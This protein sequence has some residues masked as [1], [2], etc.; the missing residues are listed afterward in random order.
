[1]DRLDRLCLQDG[2]F[3]EFFAYVIPAIFVTGEL[4]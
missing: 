1:M 4:K 3:C 2:Q